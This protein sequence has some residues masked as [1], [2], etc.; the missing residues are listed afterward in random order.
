MPLY[1]DEL[2]TMIKQAAIEN[3]NKVKTPI[4]TKDTNSEIDEAES[5]LS[6]I[7]YIESYS[8]NKNDKLVKMAQAYSDYGVLEGKKDSVRNGNKAVDGKQEKRI[9]MSLNER[10]FLRDMIDKLKSLKR[11]KCEYDF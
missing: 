5:D 3:V 2:S 10:R 6:D 1:P 4:N 8:D 7:E 9:K 11:S